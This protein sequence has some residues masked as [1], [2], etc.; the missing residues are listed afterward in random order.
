MIEMNIAELKAHL[1]DVIAQIRKTGEGV[2]IGR[3]GKP[4]AKLIPYEETPKPRK[5][6]FA[7]HLSQTD[8]ET[9]QEQVDA[10][11]D[12]ETLEGFYS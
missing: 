2:I 1:S 3:Y 4:V 10:D 8:M 12:P 7:K 11:L 9:L 5:I 6:G